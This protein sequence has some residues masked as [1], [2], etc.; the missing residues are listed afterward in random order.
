MKFSNKKIVGC[1]CKPLRAGIG[2]L[3]ITTGWNK[4]KLE[5]RYIFHNV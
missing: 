4:N 3:F 1:H 5:E 2:D